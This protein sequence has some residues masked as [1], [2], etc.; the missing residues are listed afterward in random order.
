[1]CTGNARRLCGDVHCSPCFEKSF[2]SHERSEYILDVDPRTVF[3]SS[4]K[5]FDFICDCGHCFPSILGNVTTGYWC[6]YCANKQLCEFPD[7]K[8]C[9]EKSFASHERS[10]YLLS[11]VDPRTVFRSGH[12]KFDFIC[13]CGHYFP[14]TLR[15]VTRDTWCPYCSK[16]PKKLCDYPNCKQCFKN[17]FA[18]HE[19]S[20]YILD[21]DPRTIF[22]R[23]GKEIYFICERGHKFPSILSNITNKYG[24]SWCPHCKHKTEDILCTFLEQKYPSVQRQ[25][26]A[27][28][29]KRKRF[30]VVVH[31]L[32][33]IIELDGPQHFRQ[34]SNW[35]SSD[36]T[37]VNDMYKM[38]CANDNGYSVVR[39][40]QEDVLGDRYD[41]KN[42]LANVL[43]EYSQPTNIFLCK[44]EE[45]N[46]HL[47]MF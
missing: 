21:V 18:S 20:K 25:F 13:D 14:S 15:D 27:E 37:R 4:N 41:W 6:P 45:Y 35:T 10:E 36:E 26:S 5:K 29:S 19:R 43:H 34:I 2:A 11:D 1:M 24:G 8:E 38:K 46:G 16:P 31:E 3:L 32:Q 12:E 44:N 7:C 42:E 22:R 9:F 28:W 40:L 30:D 17:S 23:S 47:N 39:I 33:I